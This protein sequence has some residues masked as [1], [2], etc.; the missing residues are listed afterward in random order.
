MGRAKG[1]YTPVAQR[2]RSASS[3]AQTG[4]GFDV[5]NPQFAAEP[6]H[7]FWSAQSPTNPALQLR[8]YLS[9]EYDEHKREVVVA[10]SQS[11]LRQRAE[12]KLEI[13]AATLP[14]ATLYSVPSSG[15]PVS[16][17]ALFDR[18]VQG[19]KTGQLTRSPEVGAY[20]GA[21]A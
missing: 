6:N 16:V 17:R 11:V 13:L 19:I 10:L 18:A 4:G 14:K 20:F 2:P 9:A 15:K 1:T 21:V 7:A 12:G 5:S 8:T 3:T